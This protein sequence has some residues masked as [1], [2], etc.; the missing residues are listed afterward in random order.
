[1]WTC[2]ERV[3]LEVSPGFL[4]LLAGLFYLDYGVG[5][6]PW[7]LLVC[8]VHELGHV[9]AALL[10]KGRPRRL[11]LSVVGAELSF[12]Y[13]R[14]LSYGEESL[15]ALAGPA[16]NLVIGVAAYCLK[17]YLPAILSLGVGGFNL[18]PILPLDGG[19]VL[20]NLLALWLEPPWPER[21]LSVTAGV[22]VGVLVGVGAIAA[23]EYA[24]V[25]LLLTAIW[26]LA[27]TIRGQRENGK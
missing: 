5:L 16:A 26:L 21:V 19:R 9:A 3:R 25:T 11:S 24:N 1:M 18:L 8:A 22:L 4:L 27:G 6:L 10:L 23:A 12:S 7:A 14:V 15:V 17:G 2:R 20:L 13:P